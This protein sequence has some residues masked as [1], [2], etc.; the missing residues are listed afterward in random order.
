VRR[1]ALRDLGAV[2]SAVVA[3]VVFGL[4]VGAAKLGIELSVAHGVIT[5]VWAPTGIALAAL[6]L[7][8]RKFWPAVA[9][10]ALVANATTGASVPEAAFISV[11]NTLEA[12]VGATLLLQVGFRPALDRLR[13]VLALVVLAAVAST[14]ISATNGVTTLWI[15][16]DV[17]GSDYGS[18]WLLWWLG[19]AM[20]DLVVAPLLLVWA[21][22]PLRHLSRRLAIEALVLLGLLVGISC[23]VFLGGYWRYPH[24]LFPLLIWSALR[25]RQQGAVT[26]SFVVAAIAITGAVRGTTPL[27]NGSTTEIVQVLEG[28]VASVTIALLIL[29]A[30]LAERS[31]AES[32]LERAHAGLA[33]AQEVAH[34]GSW[35]WN[36]G[37]NRV[38]WSDELYRLFGLEPQSLP[39][40]YES[41][42]ELVHADDREKM[43][44]ATEKAYAD[45]RPFVIEHRVSLPDGRIRWLQGRGRVITDADDKPVRMVGTSQDITERKRL[46]ELREDILATVSHELRTP[47]T[48]II[49]FAL[50]LKEKG[51]Q[52][53][54]DARS[55][56]VM[57]LAEQAE[58]LERLLSDLLDLDRL[59]RGLARPTFR[60][61]N[62]GQL[63]A[64]V[65]K[66]Y[67]ANTHP[68]VVRVQPAWAE[69]DAPKV[70]RIVENLI[71]N[72]VKHTPAGTEIWARVERSND[73]V[74][75][76]VDDRGPGVRERDRKAIFE[77]FNRGGAVP[78]QP[79]TGIGLSLVTQFAALHGGRVWVDENPGGGASFRVHL[80]TRPPH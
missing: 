53:A 4:Y 45:E 37:T 59:R 18:E 73:G 8:G 13:D 75:I 43:R 54:D 79:G 74:L 20:G 78:P 27:G 70:E 14:T 42:L 11:G 7:F 35:E 51:V 62:I 61:T 16:G 46:D 38:T 3:A 31:S 39:L 6:V 71:A 41:F 69:V 49:G 66:D 34:L 64:E 9:L 17:S 72:A 55:E 63:V 12:V 32:G 50:T 33:E 65:A 68:I 58:K 76:A 28:L 67:P 25:F 21:A 5:P 10:A 36:I 56:M 26:G 2:H 52:L 77:I 24:L 15:S 19:D 29:G 48:S 40:T 47:L 23:F 60:P 80:P 57:H 44:R 22:A 1:L 30:V